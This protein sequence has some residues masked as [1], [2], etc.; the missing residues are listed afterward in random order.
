M[1]NNKRTNKTNNASDQR[2]LAI[3]HL[4][5]NGSYQFNITFNSSEREEALKIMGILAINKFNFSGIIIPKEK[6]N[7]ALRGTIGVSIVQSCVVTLDPVKT[8]IDE[9]VKRDFSSD[10][11]ITENETITEM[12][13]N[14]DIEPLE[15]EINLIRIGC[16]ALAL[17]LPSYPKVQDAELKTSIFTEKGKLPMTDDDTKPFASLASLVDRITK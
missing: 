1:L 5:T 13:K 14:V 3:R 11:I 16:E 17:N 2:I 9:A 6:K 8:R 15:N 12:N 4:P 7:W 10:I